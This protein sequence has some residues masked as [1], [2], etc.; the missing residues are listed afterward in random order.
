ML[1][2]I[3]GISFITLVII[4]IR[5]LSDGKILKRHQYAIWLIIPVCMIL[6]PFLNINV[7]IA[8]ENEA[9]LP[10]INET[11]SFNDP[12]NTAMVVQIENDQNEQTINYSTTAIDKETVAD[13]QVV[14]EQKAVPAGR[15][16]SGDLDWG[17]LL[18]YVSLSVSAVLIITLI[19]Y[20]ASFMIYCK[21]NSRYISR[22]TESGLKIYGIDLKGTPFLLLNRIYVDS[23]SGES[24]KYTICHE[25][26]H[27]KHKDY[28]W[29]WLRYLV[30][31]LNW[32]NP[33][34]WVAFILSGRDCE[35]ACDEEVL[36][37][38]G[39]ESATD[40]AKTLY[41]MMKKRVNVP[42]S[43]TV[44]T[45]MNNGY[46]TMKRRITSIKHPAKNSY[47]ALSMCLAAVLLFSSC[48]FIKPE[49]V[50][51]ISKDDPWF[52][53]DIIEVETGAESRIT[54]SPYNEYIGSDDQYY[55][56]YTGGH[57]VTTE[58]EENSADFY[59]NDYNFYFVAVVD[60]NTKQTI[61]TIDL[62][63][64]LARYEYPK[65]TYYSN[66]IITVQSDS[67][68]RDYDPL[69]GEL[70][71]TRNGRN[72]DIGTISRRYKVGEYEVESLMMYPETGRNYCTLEIRDPDGN[73]SEIEIKDFDKN[74]YVYAVLEISDT[75]A[76]L[77]T[78]I[79]NK[80]VYYELD[81]P[82]A[83]LS[84]GDEKDYEWLDT[85]YFSRAVAG[86]DGMVYYNTGYGIFR[87][88]AANKKTEEVLSF[89]WCDLNKG[90]IENF[91]LVECSKDR[92][93][94]FGTYDET[95]VYD[96]KKGD[97]ANLIEITKA[98]KNPHAGKTILELYDR[99][100][101][102]KYTGEAIRTF[103]QTNGKY[104]I[105]VTNRYK[106]SDFYDSNDDDNNDDV[107]A[108]SGINGR[109]KLSSKLAIDIMNGEGP[110]ILM[111]VS[112][113]EH[114]NTSESLADLSPYVKDFDSDRYFTNIIEGSKTDGALYQLPISFGVEGI[115]AKTKDVSCYGNGFTFD[116]YTQFVDEVANGKDPIIYGQAVYFSMLFSGM[117]DEFVSNGKVD[118]SGPEFKALA[119]YVRDNVR[120]E[121]ISMNAWYQS[122]QSDGP[123][124]KAALEEHIDGIAD[125]FVKGMM[126]AAYGKGVSL[127]G[128][129]SFD[130]R[131]PRFVPTCSVAVSAK[132]VDKKACGE[133]VKI[134]LSDEIQ[135]K[136]A[137]NDRFV[138][139]REAFKKAGSVAIE[140]FNNGGSTSTGNRVRS[141]FTTKD[142]DFIE[143]MIL[144]CSGIK[145]EDS[146]ISIILIEE[147]PPY[148]LGQKDLDAVIKIA[149]DRIQ[150]VLDERG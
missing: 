137:L 143:N 18:Q 108:L 54:G 113:L 77:P 133:F 95:N 73:S 84:V 85:A 35:L 134:L 107:A 135:S 100:G 136:I 67:K 24:N 64:D 109:A 103:N 86:S 144:G 25:A 22:D 142:I 8:K 50:R 1:R 34:I 128:I 89:N 150:K 114:L 16:T 61:T 59:Y 65:N 94:L 138:I 49:N 33:V 13:D 91:N 66:G 29:I 30:L 115:L 7:Q 40:Y 132:T 63:K 6:L 39:N 17:S 105:E 14:E 87:L 70:I 60:K 56:L 11:V 37:V 102:D 48:T 10:E 82:T 106:Y 51:K 42:F 12:G 111:N 126:I 97:T 44:S 19:V 130:G 122:T 124:P 21:R 46:K 116:E 92:F 57:Y 58:E 99:F 120:E 2:Y 80:K 147:M 62:K 129:P 71:D 43:F 123:Q 68:V 28:I 72:F 36:S 75:K 141:D 93:I 118:L 4:F 9:V 38:F 41:G 146:D 31:A 5:A 125:Y 52:D 148:F 98:G 23:E 88:D 110:D 90:L 74:V 83:G 145:K 119:D 79:A 45:G 117:S 149:E 53:T 76:V 140:Y 47:K 139:S 112:G 32:Y 81:L 27:H 127:L 69:T 15:K 55:I 96:G 104:Y 26:C 20:N 3:I 78:S 121:G 101:V 131:G